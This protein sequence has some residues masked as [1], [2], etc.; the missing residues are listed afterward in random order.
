MPTATM[1]TRCLTISRPFCGLDGC[2]GDAG[3]RGKRRPCLRRETSGDL[4]VFIHAADR[5]SAQ[6][7]PAL[8]PTIRQPART[9]PA[10]PILLSTRRS[11]SHHVAD[12]IPITV[13][14]PHSE[15]DGHAEK[16]PRPEYPRP[17]LRR[18]GWTNLNGRWRFVF[19]DADVGRA[20]RWQDVSARSPA[21][22]AHHRRE[23][24][25]RAHRPSRRRRAGLELIPLTSRPSPRSMNGDT[26]YTFLHLDR[27]AGPA[28]RRGREGA[29]PASEEPSRLRSGSARL[30]TGRRRRAASA[31]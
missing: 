7:P 18:D 21:N 17:Q 14:R 3:T 26:I 13:T 19:D 23:I 9:H 2:T 16:L 22:Q 31:R 15:G 6:P 8:S 20:A 28:A 4:A 11:T 27:A 29:P 12:P 25:S 30:S 10:H 24:D 5:S 1:S